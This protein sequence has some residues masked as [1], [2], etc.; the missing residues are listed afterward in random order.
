MVRFFPCPYHGESALA[1]WFHLAVPAE[2]SLLKV[3]TPADRLVAQWSLGPLP[4]GESQTAL[5]P[6]GIPAF[7]NGL[8]YI[9]LEV[10]E[11][12][13]YGKWAILR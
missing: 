5:T 1:V 11:G 4:G 9:V 3:F 12:R 6:E 7:A 10:P 13:V 8:Y 2:K